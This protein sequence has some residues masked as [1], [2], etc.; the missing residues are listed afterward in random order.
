[1]F[2]MCCNKYFWTV[3]L[4]IYDVL[5]SYLMIICTYEVRSHMSRTCTGLR[6]GSRYQCILYPANDLEIMGRNANVRLCVY[7]NIAQVKW[8]D[9]KAPAICLFLN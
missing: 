8:P 2:I 4:K 1:M 5:L 6:S 7:V 3:L 9:V